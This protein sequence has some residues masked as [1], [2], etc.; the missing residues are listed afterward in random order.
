[1]NIAIIPARG[2]SKRIHRKNIKIF[3]GRPII[4][5]PIDACRESGLFDRIIVST[6]DEEIRQLA[7]NYG[8]EV[9]DRKKS[10][11]DDV[12]PIVPVIK[13][14]VESLEN[15]EEISHVCCIFACAPLIE[16]ND[17]HRAYEK[18]YKF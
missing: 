18:N 8:V 10:L 6:D 4:L 16:A 2:G 3:N 11:S 15:T 5:Y 9:H 13:D 12:T 17:L 1:M 14:V 7:I